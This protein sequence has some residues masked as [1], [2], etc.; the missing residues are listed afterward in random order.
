[1]GGVS[2][3]LGEGTFEMSGF[4]A[5]DLRGFSHGA[6]Q[7][8]ADDQRLNPSLVLQPEF[9]WEWNGGD[10]RVEFIPFARLDSHDD[11]RSHGDIR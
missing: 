9:L 10:D 7:P 5:G 3:A 4:M 2:P 6:I 11:E 8:G 1:M